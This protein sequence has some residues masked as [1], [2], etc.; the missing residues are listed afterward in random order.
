MLRRTTRLVRQRPRRDRLAQERLT[1]P[2]E[3]RADRAAADALGR[4]FLD[5]RAMNAP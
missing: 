5:A 2:N 3:R 4:K 1:L